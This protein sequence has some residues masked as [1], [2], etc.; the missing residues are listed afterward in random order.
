M[1]HSA[2]ANDKEESI[3]ADKMRVCGRIVVDVGVALL[4][5]IALAGFLQTGQDPL[6]HEYEPERPEIVPRPFSLPQWFRICS[7]SF[8]YPS[9][10]H[11]FGH[12][13]RGASCIPFLELPWRLKAQF[14]PSPS[15][16]SVNPPR[17]SRYDGRVLARYFTIGVR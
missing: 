16:I 14:A 3:L 7:S 1:D 2:V 15:L 12:E 8:P 5:V 6:E 13:H 4:T 17:V 10:L 9:H 11:F